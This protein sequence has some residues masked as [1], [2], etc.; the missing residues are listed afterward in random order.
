MTTRKFL[1]VSLLRMK[2]RSPACSRSYSWPASRAAIRRGSASGL[3]ASSTR[4]SLVT[5]SPA[6][7]T[8]KWR[9]WVS[10]TPTKKDVSASS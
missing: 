9:D 3:A 2:K 7:I 8:M 10:P 1:W 5:W 6:E 4:S